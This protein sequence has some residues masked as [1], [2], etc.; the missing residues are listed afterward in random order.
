M[1]LRPHRAVEDVG[2]VVGVDR[3]RDEVGPFLLPHLERRSPGRVV[4]P[5]ID[6]R[7]PGL[8]HEGIEVGQRREGAR[9]EE[10]RDNLKEGLLNLSLGLRPAPL[11]G[12]RPEAVVTGKGEEP[13]V[14]ERLLAVPR[15]HDDFHTVVEARGGG[16]PQVREGAHVFAHRGREVLRLHEAQVAAARVA[17]DVTE[18]V[19]APAAL[20]GERDVERGV[21]HLRLH[22][23]ARFEPDHRRLGR[24]RAQRAQARLDDG[25]AAR[26]TGGP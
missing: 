24:L 22:A 13:R 3:Q 4:H 12:P 5:P 18:G 23:G 10:M 6:L 21:I 7:E 16:A 2:G 20:L 9:I 19:H 26:E 8:G 15:L 1:P 11:A 25:M 14:V 17:E